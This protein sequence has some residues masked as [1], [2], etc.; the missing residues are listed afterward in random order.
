[1]RILPLLDP[2]PCIP[3]PPCNNSIVVQTDRPYSQVG[4]VCGMQ[5][6]RT[7]CP[8]PVD[9]RPAG[10]HPY[11]AAVLVLGLASTRPV[12]SGANLTVHA[13]PKAWE[14]GAYCRA[15]PL[16][17]SLWPPVLCAA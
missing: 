7:T 2:R 17:S 11:G 4:L 15:C 1:M 13:R 3:G 14:C 6:M 16:V 8:A 10:A 5:A 12:V 9:H